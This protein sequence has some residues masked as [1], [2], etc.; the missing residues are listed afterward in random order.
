MWWNKHIKRGMR[1][2]LTRYT[3]KHFLRKAHMYPLKAVSHLAAE[4]P[5]WCMVFNEW[6]ELETRVSPSW[7]FSILKE[8]LQM[9]HDLIKYITNLEHMDLCFQHL[10]EK[11]MQNSTMNLKRCILKSLINWDTM[12]VHFKS[13][14]TL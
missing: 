9:L 14:C 8:S 13:L 1:D 7:I 12:L 4:S 5:S 3:I 6:R 10:R 11:W 2:F